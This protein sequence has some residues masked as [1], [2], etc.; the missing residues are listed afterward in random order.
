MV[1]ALR[2]LSDT[3]F[4]TLQIVTKVDFETENHRHLVG[5]DDP[6]EE[7]LP[8]I[9]KGVLRTGDD[10]FREDFIDGKLADRTH[11]FDG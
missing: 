3:K 6:L 11:F 5:R 4:R 9:A 10:F 2:L 1:D 7:L 8:N